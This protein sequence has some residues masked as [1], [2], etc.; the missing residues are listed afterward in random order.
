MI[1]CMSLEPLQTLS[2]SWIWKLFLGPYSAWYFPLYIYIILRFLVQCSATGF[3]SSVNTKWHQADSDPVSPSLWIMFLVLF[4]AII[5]PKQAKDNKSFNFDYSYWSHTS[6]TLHSL[7]A[8]VCRRC[9]RT[10]I[11]TLIWFPRWIY[12][13]FFRFMSLWLTIDLLSTAWRCQLCLSDASVQRHW[14]GN[15]ATCIWGLQRLHLC[16]WPDRCWQVLHHDGETGC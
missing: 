5:N 6:V 2:H 12:L 13:T 7:R 14:R 15:V 11:Y 10:H 4:S 9:I 16:L 3:S 8:K 1:K